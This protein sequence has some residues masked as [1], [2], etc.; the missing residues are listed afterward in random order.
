MNRNA[1]LAVLIAGAAGLAP[2]LAR[3]QQ[4]PPAADPP[5]ERAPDP[6]DLAGFKLDELLDMS[7]YVASKR[8][9]KVS[10]APASITAHAAEDV[11]TLG[12]YTIH[13]LA[14]VTAGYSG[15]IM[16]GEKVL[17][18]RGQKAGSF[19]NNKHLIYVDGITINHARNY[20]GPIDEE[21]P[22]FFAQRVEFLRGPA[23]ALHGTSAFF[24][25][26]NVVPKEPRPGA[27]SVEARLSLGSRDGERRLAANTLFSDERGGGRLCFGYYDKN[28]S[29]DRVGV[30][31]DDA[32]LFW[33]DQKSVFL[34]A[35]YTLRT[36]PFAGLTPGFIYLRKNGGL[37]ESWNE[38][39][40]SHEL[41]DLTW[42]TVIPY[43]KYSR[44]LGEHLTLSAHVA[45][46]T[47]REKGY[48]T[49][50]GGPDLKGGFNGSGAAFIS[51]D[52]QVDDVQGQAE[53]DWQLASRTR[54]TGGFNL[55]TRRQ[56]GR[57]R[58]YG[59]VVSADPGMPYVA[60]PTLA[61]PSDRYTIYSAYAQLRQDLPLGRGLSLT[62][63]AR[64]DIGA[65][66][67]QTY[68]Q[69][70][71]RL[72]LV[73][74]IAD[75]VTFKAFFG[76]ALRMP[77]IKEIGLNQESRAILE[78]TGLPT[79]A[80]RD[81]RAETIRSF[82]AGPSYNGRNLS[83]SVTAFS[84]RTTDL[85]DGVPYQ[86]VNIFQNAAGQTDA[87]GVEAEMQIA[88]TRNLRFLAS[89][90]WAHAEDAMNQDLED[91]PIQHATAGAIYRMPRLRL[92]A[93]ATSRWVSGYR[94]KLAGE[95]PP[96]FFISD[97]NLIW[98]LTR[99][100]DFELQVRNVF[101]HRAKLPKH[102]R[103]DVP[104]PGVNVRGTVAYGF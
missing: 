74:R 77:G 13:D 7:V 61:V 98:G 93:S 27:T 70:S 41:N 72:G 17:E 71:P 48:Y 63:G 35:A 62:V 2:P 14:N 10:E 73:Q 12:N 57:D 11:Q 104:L 92:T 89:Y 96:G 25:V 6:D 80:I 30:V 91:V 83:L 24:G 37:G 97:L 64:E 53:V 40:S 28:A 18:T 65:S 31:D 45:S 51:Y 34:N 86:G 19:N 85:L 36:T 58:S 82:E 50:L 16:Y 54:L 87:L 44:R 76:T 15:T 99:A 102:G 52:T 21:L 55:D 32:N 38:N 101:D 5:P 75:S 100:L 22:L 88:P 84:N 66:S 94:S 42:E 29:R 26:I 78:R 20:K 90:S 49:P 68:Q 33:D 4:P 56:R 47:G 60:D 67:S 39:G 79:E 69:L 1:T 3:A 46:N 95:R 81:L 23:S 8:D 9:E 103:L 43:L 59:Y